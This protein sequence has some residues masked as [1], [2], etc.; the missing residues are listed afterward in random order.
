MNGTALPSEFV[1]DFPLQC[2]DGLAGDR[3]GQGSGWEDHLDPRRRIAVGAVG[4]DLAVMTG[5]VAQVLLTDDDW[6][7]TLEGI[8]G[9]L[10][11]GG[12]LVFE[13]RRPDRRVRE[14]WAADTAHDVIDVPGVGEVGSG[15]RSPR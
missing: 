11:P 6:N 14:E 3:E 13:I 1:G 2:D 5:N 8:H 10:A 15:V 4:A 7:R 9:A 12:H